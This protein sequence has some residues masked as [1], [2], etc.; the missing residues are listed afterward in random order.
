MTIVSH[1]LFHHPRIVFPRLAPQNYPNIRN[2]SQKSRKP[3]EKATEIGWTAEALKSEAEAAQSPGGEHSPPLV[4]PQPQLTCQ[5][6]ERFPLQ[7]S[8]EG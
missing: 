1:F 4:P 7:Q 8:Q 5:C 2:S 6:K 3:L